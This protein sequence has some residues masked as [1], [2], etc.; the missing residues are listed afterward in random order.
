M[1][2]LRKAGNRA[3]RALASDLTALVAHA[4]VVHGVVSDDEPSAGSPGLRGGAPAR[5]R[6]AYLC[7]A[8]QS[9]TLEPETA[10]GT[11]C[12][13]SSAK[14]PVNVWRQESESPSMPTVQM[15]LQRRIG[16]TAV[17]CCW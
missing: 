5:Q 10:G 7:E 3:R 15:H 2:S 9:G 11:G 17:K 6:S 12:E 4:A 1:E 13:G 8:A 16:N 14:L